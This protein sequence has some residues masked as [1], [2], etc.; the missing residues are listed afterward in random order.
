MEHDLR[1]EREDRYALLQLGVRP[2]E[3]H[4]AVRWRMEGDLPVL[5]RYNVD[6]TALL[7][8]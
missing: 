3:G 6:S 2:R 1:N 5:L 7:L 4:G 8:N